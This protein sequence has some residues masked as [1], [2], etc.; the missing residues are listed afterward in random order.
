MRLFPVRFLPLVVPGAKFCSHDENTT[1]IWL[2]EF[3]FLALRQ[4]AQQRVL[5]FQCNPSSSPVPSLCD[6][7][8]VYHTSALTYCFIVP[9][10]SGDC[11]Q[12]TT[13]GQPNVCLV[14]RRCIWR[15]RH[16]RLYKLSHHTNLVFI[17]NW[18]IGLIRTIMTYTISR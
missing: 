17:S 13:N 2:L 11:M 16:L 12:T 7:I 5:P 10:V 15:K 14:S 3:Q 6:C 9:A 4:L 1:R 18:V 8:I